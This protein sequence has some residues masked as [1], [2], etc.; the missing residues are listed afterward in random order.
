MGVFARE[1]EGGGCGD[2][3]K[4]EGEVERAQGAGAGKEEEGEGGFGKH[5]LERLEGW[6]EL[7][8]GGLGG[9]WRLD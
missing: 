9:G 6:V 5:F 7:G 8:G 1:E 4:G 2:G 3:A